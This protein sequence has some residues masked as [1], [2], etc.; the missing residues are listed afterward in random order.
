MSE[1]FLAHSENSFGKSHALK[2][3][4]RG[5][6]ERV[7]N[8]ACT[9]KLRK[10]LVLAALLH[11]FGKYLDKFQRY[12]RGKGSSVPHA[13]WG[14][15]LAKLLRSTDVSFAVDGHH[16]GLPD[17]NKW[18]YEH[19]FHDDAINRQVEELFKRFIVD[20]G[21][22]DKNI[23]DL[24]NSGVEAGREWDI[25]TRYI[26]SCLT[27]ADWLDTE[28]HFSLE[29]SQRREHRILDATTA[30]CLVDSELN[31]L[32][33]DSKSINEL[34]AKALQQALKK[35]TLPTGFFSL[36]LPTGLGKTLTSFRWAL[37]HAKAN[38]LERI[39]IVLPYTN[40][41]DQTAQRLKAILGQDSV[42]EHHSSY[43]F[44]S[45]DKDQ[46]DQQK[47]ACENWDFPIILTT[48][49]QFF[50]TLFSNHPGKC[51]KLHNIAKSVVILDEVQTLPKR[52]VLPTLD[53][54]QDM[55]DFIDTSFV[56]CTATMPAFEK[57]DSFPGIENIVELADNPAD[58]F[59][60][61][62]RVRYSFLN[63]LRQANKALLLEN[64]QVQPSSTLV[65]ANTKRLV[66]ELYKEAASWQ[67]WDAVYH[68]ST[69]MCPHHRKKIISKINTIVKDK[70]KKI[71]VFSTQLVE[72]GVDLDF[73]CVFRELAPLESII[74]A[75]G[76]CNRE[77]LLSEG[78]VTLFCLDEAK[79]P[80]NF[81]KTQSGVVATL[82][83]AAP[84]CLYTYETFQRYYAQIMGLYVD[85]QPVTQQREKQDFAT[86]AA[87]Y[88]I[89]SNNTQPVFVWNYDEDSRKLYETLRAKE[90]KKLPLSRD[91][92]RAMQ[93]YSVQV[94]DTDLFKSEGS[95]EQAYSGLL[96]WNGEYSAH[97]G[98]HVLPQNADGIIM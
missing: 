51:R 61:T 40:I 90:R 98:L 25:N 94:Y 46:D 72:A 13:R 57:G 95:W 36:N 65:I 4:L 19:T 27:D 75:A 60:R 53:M 2:D 32:F 9:D 17:F 96:I 22:T 52:I 74:Q 84:D 97:T 42:L 71:L 7:T 82:L 21:L 5:V 44:K 59:G 54:L 18:E 12:L 47:F 20:T 26:F 39:I 88:R 16:A 67:G 81:Y 70:S 76:R 78:I 64:L 63:G 14:A 11:D 83:A 93:Q 50:E 49:V 43:I 55:Q 15:L 23:L 77:G 38:K 30:I 1:I 48:S 68:L 29:K 85:P 24:T 28:K 31:R 10:S 33:D 41:I 3:H 79:F 92:F 37:E 45:D 91:E 58:L 8:W 66:L 34:R 35:A 80:D 69:G 56:F 87:M 89:I 6:E 73:P 62:Q 86:T